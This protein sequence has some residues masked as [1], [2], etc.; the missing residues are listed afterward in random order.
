MSDD[1]SR[2]DANAMDAHKELQ[3]KKATKKK[4]VKSYT[5]AEAIA[6]LQRLERAGH[7]QSGYYK[8]VKHRAQET[9]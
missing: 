7:Q 3:G 1:V 8:D 4:K 9:A 6:E 2:P 5:H